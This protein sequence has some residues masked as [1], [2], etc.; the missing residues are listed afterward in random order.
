MQK[1]KNHIPSVLT[2]FVFGVAIILMLTIA[3]I[4]G[5]VS[6]MS[7]INGD[8]DPAGQMIASGVFAFQAVLLVIC[9]WFVLEKSRGREAADA[10]FKFPFALWQV[11][12]ILGF[13]FFGAIFG[14]AITLTG[15]PL[16]GW[17]ILPILSVLMIT[18]PIWMF[19]GIG[20]NGIYPGARWRFFSILGLSMT[21]APFIMF[22]LESVLLIFIVILASIYLAVSQPNLVNEISRIAQAVSNETS[23]EAILSMVAPYITNPLVI[24]TAIGY[25]SVL[26]PVIEELLKPLAVWLFARKIET[27]AQGFVLGMLSG[28]GFALFESLNASAD[29]STSWAVIVGARAGTSLLHMTTSG[30]MGWG[31]VTVFKEKKYLRFLGTLLSAVLLHGIWNACALGAGITAS[32]EFLGKPEWLINYTPALLCGLLVMAVGIFAVLTASNRRLKKLALIAPANELEVENV[33]VKETIASAVVNEASH[34]N[35]PD[36]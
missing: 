24:G 9:G 31:I 3:A 18:L 23:P 34:E 33:S 26:V 11:A 35:E 6:I 21:I 4:F 12:V 15:I 10:P 25:I 20:S 17:L 13:V 32:G 30:L 16:L 2:L 29:G 5:I 22:M 14:G 8:A 19:Y 28:A 7:L 1:N 27:P 36:K